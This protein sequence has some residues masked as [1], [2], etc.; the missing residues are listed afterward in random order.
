MRAAEQSR[1][2]SFVEAWGN[3]AIGFGINF[4]GNLLVLPAFGFHVRVA[5]ALGIGLVFT[6]VSVIRSYFVRRLF[7]RLRVTWGNP[8]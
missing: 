7:E 3:I 2:M 5:D 8:A 1:V 4:A 6:V